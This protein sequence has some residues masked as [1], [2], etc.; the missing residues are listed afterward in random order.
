MQIRNLSDAPIEFWTTSPIGET[1]NV[2]LEPGSTYLFA[3]PPELVT[4]RGDPAMVA[5][6]AAEGRAVAAALEA[7]ADSVELLRAAAQWAVRAEQLRRAREG[8]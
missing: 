5:R 7:L 4:F 6:V 3:V 1:R 8:S 2:T